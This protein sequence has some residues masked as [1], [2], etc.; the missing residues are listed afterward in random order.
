MCVCV[1]A[2]A[3]DPV[4][5]VAQTR[6][7]CYATASTWHTPNPVLCSF[8]TLYGCSHPGHC[9]IICLMMMTDFT[10][11]FYIRARFLKQ[12]LENKLL[13]FSH[14]MQECI[15]INL[16]HV[17]SLQMN[18]PTW[19]VLRAQP[20]QTV[21]GSTAQHVSICVKC[22]AAGLWTERHRL[23]FVCQLS[24]QLSCLETWLV[25]MEGM[26][27]RGCWLLDDVI[28]IFLKILKG[29]SCAVVVWQRRP[30]L[31]I[32]TGWCGSRLLSPLFIS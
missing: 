22:V 14:H 9:V 6:S 2:C 10:L 11:L 12:H 5:Q 4:D 18:V 31:W 24:R 16:T 26:H 3:S 13:S 8:N 27:G 23:P 20:L 32:W 25:G 19:H 30:A 17:S 15:Y 28:C 1:C 29:R 21:S 7:T